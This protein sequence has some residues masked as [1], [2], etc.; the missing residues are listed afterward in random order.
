MPQEDEIRLRA[1]L[2][3]EIEILERQ[4]GSWVDKTR[5]EFTRKVERKQLLQTELELSKLR[6]T[7]AKAAKAAVDA[8]PQEQQ[9]FKPVNERQAFV[10]PIV[11]KKGWS[12]F[13]LAKHSEVDFHTVQSYLSGKRK[14]YSST[15]MKLA[16]AL[17][18]DIHDL[19]K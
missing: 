11:E 4:L 6:E 1:H 7:L 14:S 2:E 10:M 16:K 13:D 12:I 15:R 3:A 17:S 5:P 18:V 19:P 9:D 8:P